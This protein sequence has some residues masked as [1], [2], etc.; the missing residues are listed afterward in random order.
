MKAKRIIEIS[1]LAVIT[2]A[3]LALIISIQMVRG[4]NPS[5][6]FIEAVSLVKS[7]DNIY[8]LLNT[9]KSKC[10]LIES[11]KVEIDPSNELIY[12][13]QLD[14]TEKEIYWL[15]HY[16]IN[17][18]DY[19]VINFSDTKFGELYNT[20]DNNSEINS[21]F[22]K[23]TDS[24][25]RAE[26][27]YHYDNPQVYWADYAQYVAIMGNY[28]IADFTYYFSENGIGY[29]QEELNAFLENKIA[30]ENKLQ[31][32][33]NEIAAQ[34]STIDNDWGKALY[35]SKWISDNTSY[36]YSVL[37]EKDY[38]AKIINGS[39]YSAV[40]NN[41]CVCR[42]Y[43]ELYKYLLDYVGIN[44]Q[45]CLGNVEQTQNLPAL[46]V[47]GNHIWN[48]VEI[49]GELCNI[50]VTGIDTSDDDI[51]YDFALF[52]ASDKQLEKTHTK[53]GD[54]NIAKCD[55]TNNSFFIHE[56]LYST[57][58]TKESIE[59]AIEYAI[60]NNYNYAF[61]QYENPQDAENAYNKYVV[62]SLTLQN[63]LLQYN[64]QY[65][66]IITIDEKQMYESA[67]DTTSGVFYII[68]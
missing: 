49:G 68:L 1:L 4:V 25:R 15:I 64:K 53:T 40:I 41:T 20:S 66:E 63:I 3:V 39:I 62:R 14:E 18:Y 7:E 44:N 60:E 9:F 19:L 45:Q 31:D 42:G 38:N 52:G 10:E 34:T 30:F 28:Y 35:I 58:P 16:S 5:E 29:T 65:D 50:D 21:A 6:T 33:S 13:N 48:V 61:V 47:D 17:N 46:D 26:T 37:D 43:T 12:Y 22:L 55:S 51:A 27:A 56:N 23:F 2:L 36:D 67:Y 24:I 32:I 11:S 57:G 54:F 59:N 8:H